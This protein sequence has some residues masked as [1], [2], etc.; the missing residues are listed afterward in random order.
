MY[1]NLNLN[2]KDLKKISPLEKSHKFIK[3]IED[4]RYETI[5]LLIN[6][7]T[8]NYLI[9]KDHITNDRKELIKMISIIKSNIL[10]K[11][12]YIIKVVDYSV[13][14][15]SKLCSTFFILKLFY[16]FPKTD[17]LKNLQNKQLR[18][19]NYSGQE[20]GIFLDDIIHGISDL[21]L[22]GIYFEDL[23]P[24]NIT[25]DVKS[26]KWKIIKVDFFGDLSLNR[27]K[28]KQMNNI[29]ENKTLYLSPKMFE[30]LKNNNVHFNINLKKEISFILAL[31]VLE[32]GNMESIQ[33]IYNH[34]FNKIH[35]LA[36]DD[37]LQNFNSKYN[38][39]FPKLTKSIKS[40]LTYDEQNRIA[41]DQLNKNMTN[42]HNKNN[43]KNQ[44]Y[45][46]TPN[47]KNK[48]FSKRYINVNKNI[49]T[50]NIKNN[51]SLNLYIKKNTIIKNNDKFFDNI[52][53]NVKSSKNYFDYPKNKYN[54][55][56]IINFF[57]NSL[58][59]DP[60]MKRI[61]NESTFIK[62]SND[63]LTQNKSNS[64]NKDKFISKRNLLKINFTH[65]KSEGLQKLKF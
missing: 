53:I 3:K 63:L 49:R 41:Y 52:K 62:S 12:D 15:E 25:Y 60:K 51:N 5:S 43:F 28:A 39:N 26:Q 54:P 64:L 47:L 13:E 17:L 20:L 59:N 37:H 19:E 4:K 55:K 10:L 9:Q 34:E 58:F 1:T 35:F 33:N 32:I 8:R 44:N 14:E 50:P 30:N 42:L 40:M 61:N 31:C 6:S 16:P 21:D 23:R 46:K 36:L 18:G 2:E 11:S 56:K 65:F 57:D 24:D 29:F 45:S 27:I 38:D 7:K 48:F 22:N